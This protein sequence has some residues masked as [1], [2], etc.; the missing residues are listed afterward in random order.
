MYFVQMILN[1]NWLFFWRVCGIVIIHH[2][3]FV[4]TWIHEEKLL[5]MCSHSVSWQ[6]G[7]DWPFI[8]W[9]SITQLQHTHMHTHTYTNKKNCRLDD[10]SAPAVNKSPINTHAHQHT[11]LAHW[12]EW[13]MSVSQH[14]LVTAA[15]MLVWECWQLDVS[16]VTHLQLQYS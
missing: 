5:C 8:N 15:A 7:A 4:V 11:H 2:M 3:W 6:L 12:I 1:K 9:S 14:I 10:F 16:L 13:F